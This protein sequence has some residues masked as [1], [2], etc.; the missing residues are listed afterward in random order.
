[1][2]VHKDKTR[3]STGN[4]F[5]VNESKRVIDANPVAVQWP[6]TDSMAARGNHHSLHPT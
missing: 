6:V 3:M 4:E 2:Y 5:R 1:M